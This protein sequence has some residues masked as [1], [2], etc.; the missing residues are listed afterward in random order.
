MFS[1]ATFVFSDQI[2][3]QLLIGLTEYVSSILNS[4]THGNSKCLSQDEMG[5]EARN[6]QCVWEFI[7][8]LQF[9]LEKILQH[10]FLLVVVRYLFFVTFKADL[11]FFQSEIAHF[12]FAFFL[13][14]Y[15]YLFRGFAFACCAMI[16]VRWCPAT[17]SAVKWTRFIVGEII[18]YAI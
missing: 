16:K 6:A 10:E 3:L 1:A 15:I 4:D 18:T 14:R 2:I 12:S 5:K 11:I 7:T 13:L 9:N 17:I 8:K